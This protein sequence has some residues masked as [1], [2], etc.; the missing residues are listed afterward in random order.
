MG[1]SS[2]VS[3]SGVNGQSSTATISPS[4]PIRLTAEPR[5][6]SPVIETNLDD[7]NEEGE[8]DEEASDSGSDSEES[9][10]HAPAR[11]LSLPMGARPRARRL[12]TYTSSDGGMDLEDDVYGGSARPETG[13]GSWRAGSVGSWR[14]GSLGAG[15]AGRANSW[16]AASF[17]A[18][19]GTISGQGAGTGNDGGER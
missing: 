5:E 12:S 2:A 19:H 17:M 16:R 11:P 3:I 8:Q 15:G 13:M 1:D 9:E 6:I 7:I 18:R 4:S 14:P 10:S